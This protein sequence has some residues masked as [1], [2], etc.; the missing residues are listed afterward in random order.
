MPPLGPPHTSTT[1]IVTGI[2][3]YTQLFKGY[4]FTF[5]VIDKTTLQIGV[6]DCS[7]SFYQSGQEKVEQANL[8]YDLFFKLGDTDPNQFLTT[9]TL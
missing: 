2:H 1:T 7:S 4:D 5:V 8:N 9:E 3:I 6:Y